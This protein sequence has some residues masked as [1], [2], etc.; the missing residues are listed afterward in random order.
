MITTITPNP[1][2]DTVYRVPHWVPGEGHRAT[3]VH[4]TPGG[5]GL[6]VAKVLRDL[7]QEVETAGFLGG[8]TASWIEESLKAYGIV[9]A[10]T[11]I[12]GETRQ[13]MTILEEDGRVSELRE[14]GPTLS[15]E[16]IE[17]FFRT[18]R[19]EAPFLSCNGSLPMGLGVD[20]YDRLLEQVGS[21]RLIV[22]TSGAGLRHVVFESKE[23]PLAI[24]PNA[25][26]IR[27]LFGDAADVDPIALLRHPALLPIPVVLLTLGADGATAKVED[28]IYRVHVPSIDA[29]NPVGSGDATVAG[30]LDGFLQK[31]DV[32]ALLAHAM[33]AGSA[34]A[35]ETEI[36]HVDLAVVER[37]KKDIVIK[38]VV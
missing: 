13:T 30:L 34:N 24:K 21:D 33:A 29:V 15:T 35:C 11:P 37:I 22:D 38:E 5:K 19:A 36:G 2:V 31:M 27:E 32:R 1:A 14:P 17:H 26:E 18:L 16:E 8:M 20:F 28:K 7:G 6:N 9:P 3:D 10:F 25:D 12:A 4:R 23:K